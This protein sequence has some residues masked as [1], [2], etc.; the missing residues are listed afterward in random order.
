MDMA[1]PVKDGISASREIAAK[2]PTIPIVMH[3]LHYS[4]EL[5]L[6]AKKA[7]AW[8]VVPK[9]EAS[10]ELLKTIDEVLSASKAKANSSAVSHGEMNH[11]ETNRSNGHAKQEPSIDPTASLT[12]KITTAN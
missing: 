10:D 2:M 6:E 8:A 9:A 4:T 12:S 3:T 5:E 11:G 1:M 7:G